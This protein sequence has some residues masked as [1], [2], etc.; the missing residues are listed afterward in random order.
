MKNEIAMQ[1]AWL[2]QGQPHEEWKEGDGDTACRYQ[3]DEDAACQ[4]ALEAESID[5]G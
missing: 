2:L 1:A 4:R 5:N 3:V